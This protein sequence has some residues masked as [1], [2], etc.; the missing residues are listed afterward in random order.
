M[1]HSQVCLVS[2]QS[3][4]STDSREEVCSKWNGREE[5]LTLCG[6][7]DKSP[8]LAESG[9][10]RVYVN[11]CVSGLTCGD[12]LPSLMHFLSCM[13]ASRS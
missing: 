2:S 12:Y 10:A 3:N 4:A 13:G 6:N 8:R 1:A 11:V 7:Q 5:V 9:A